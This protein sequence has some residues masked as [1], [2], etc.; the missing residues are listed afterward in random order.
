[1]VLALKTHPGLLIL[2]TNESLS[3]LLSCH[4]LQAEH[5]ELH[6][7]LL[8]VCEKSR[9]QLWSWF[10][11]SCLEK[12][13]Q[14]LLSSLFPSSILCARCAHHYPTGNDSGLWS[15]LGK[16]IPH[17]HRLVDR[18]LKDYL[19]HQLHKLICLRGLCSPLLGVTAPV[20][21]N[22]GEGRILG[23]EFITR[24][25]RSRGLVTLP[26]SSLAVGVAG[27]TCGAAAIFFARRT[28]SQ[29]SH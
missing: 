16:R 13:L 26:P 15:R 27:M 17:L 23:E 3:F 4:W 11:P 19:L 7:N 20:F 1:M 18:R 28:Q 5:R 8:L 10:L 6:N 22:T 14:F 2:I 24:L 29:R 12:R 25:P 21:L 9:S